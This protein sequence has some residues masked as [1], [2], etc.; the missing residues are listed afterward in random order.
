MHAPVVPYLSA[1]DEI[2]CMKTGK[3]GD[4]IRRAKKF[5]EDADK[6]VFNSDLLFHT[7][8]RDSFCEKWMQTSHTKEEGPT[9]T[10]F[11]AYLQ[12]LGIADLHYSFS[13]RYLHGAF[14]NFVRA[15]A[16]ELLANSGQRI[17]RGL[18][19][20]EFIANVP[21]NSSA[22]V[23]CGED[24]A[25]NCAECPKCH[26]QCKKL[27]TNSTTREGKCVTRS[28]FDEASGCG[29][30]DKIEPLDP[31]NLDVNCDNINEVT[32]GQLRGIG[33]NKIVYEGYWKGRVYAVKMR[34][35]SSHRLEGQT[36]PP[37]D[38]TLKEAAL[39][40]GLRR[41]PNIIPLVGFCD[42][43]ALTE[44][45]QPLQDFAYTGNL[46]PKTR[47][48][49]ALE[50][51]RSVDQIHSIPGGLLLHGDLTFKQYLL[52]ESGTL[53]LGDLDT[54]KYV[55]DER[56]RR[57]VSGGN[58]NLAP[59][60]LAGI[61]EGQLV[62][63]KTDIYALGN[64]IWSL[65][66]KEYIFHYVDRQELPAKILNGLRPNVTKVAGYPQS[67][68]EVL[69]ECWALA[70]ESRPTASHVVARIQEALSSME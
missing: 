32:I 64:M 14:E 29:I 70:P 10:A 13:D 50:I 51:A 30:V 58:P 19:F 21:R 47:V 66:S 53:V 34:K 4:V 61:A 33:A 57:P 67:I 54:V 23:D 8:Q 2:A 37:V 46:T 28:Q 60:Q 39:L 3:C 16:Q 42:G 35:P 56:C 24:F 43:V 69:L 49:Y 7:L 15:S 36:S 62:D 5:Y 55:G 52:L 27:V 68:T 44:I 20:S 25:V 38:L 12:S 17:E 40:H 9:A 18:P 6:F 31:S 59:E 41:Q 11:I 48:Q 45:G 63:E 1:D 22:Q 65:L 26:G